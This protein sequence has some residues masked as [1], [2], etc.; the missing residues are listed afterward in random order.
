MT[1]NTKTEAWAIADELFP[2]DYAKDE[3]AS[4]AAGYEIHRSTV[5]D[6]GAWISDLGNRLEIN[7]ADGHTVN[8]WIESENGETA[9]FAETVITLDATI[10]RVVGR[11]TVLTLATAE[12]RLTASTTCR[13]IATFERDAATLIKRAKRASKNGDFVSVNLSRATYRGKPLRDFKSV[14]YEEWHGCGASITADGV[15]LTPSEKYNADPAHDIYLTGTLGSI[16]DEF[17]I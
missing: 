7:F 5:S 2:T 6:C 9:V 3:A 17:T 1:A 10:N 8:I 16:F 13:E 12:L 4:A 15:H 11:E 14:A